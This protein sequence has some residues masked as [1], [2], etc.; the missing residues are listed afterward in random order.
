M[1]I[2]CTL[3]WGGV[4][5][6]NGAAQELVGGNMVHTRVGWGGYGAALERVG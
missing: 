1:V 2:C 6:T 5:W 3:E 4:K